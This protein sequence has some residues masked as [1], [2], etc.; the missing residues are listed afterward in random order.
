[1]KNNRYTQEIKNVTAPQIMVEKTVAMLSDAPI[2]A[3]VIAFEKPKRRGL[4]FVSCVAAVLALVIGLSVIPFNKSSTATDN[5]HSFVLTVGAAEISSDV[6][7]EVGELSN[8]GSC[9]GFRPKDQ[10][11]ALENP[12]VWQG[13]YDLIQMDRMF[14]PQEF[15]IQGDNIESVTYTTHNCRLAFD[16]NFEGIVDVDMLTTEELTS[17]GEVGVHRYNSYD[18]AKSCTLDYQS[19]RE[20]IDSGK[21]FAIPKFGVEFAFNFEEGEH[22][23]MVEDKHSIDE[24]PLF[25]ETFNAHADEF[26]LDITANFK[27]GVSVTKTLVFQCENTSDRGLVLYA[28]EV[29]A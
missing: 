8:F 7:V 4:K 21:W 27:D 12:A 2:T 18:W 9:A 10:E 20:C 23:F 6:F 17:N 3:E 14:L 19:Q 25:E 24:T 5:E 11:A 13:E 26:S 15:D 28:K 16:T 29:N 22:T 1:M